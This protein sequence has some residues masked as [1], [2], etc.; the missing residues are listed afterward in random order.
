M[1]APAELSATDESL[2]NLV[3]GLYGLGDEEIQIVEEA[4]AR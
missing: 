2:D 4:T 3:Y 1:G